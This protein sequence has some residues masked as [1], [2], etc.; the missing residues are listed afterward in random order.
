M[1]GC[2]GSATRQNDVGSASPAAA[3]AA[4]APTTVLR[5]YV[6][7]AGTGQR[8]GPFDSLVD[9]RA[10]ASAGDQIRPEREPA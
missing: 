5:F 2:C 1:A 4:V 10:G 8:L 6:E 3:A 7:K 9:A